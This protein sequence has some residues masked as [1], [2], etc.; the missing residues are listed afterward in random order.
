MR[1]EGRTLRS[2]R[3]ILSP[4]A[5]SEK[6]AFIQDAN[7]LYRLKE[8]DTLM[9]R[10]EAR[11]ATHPR[12]IPTHWFLGLAL[13][14]KGRYAEAL[15]AYQIIRKNLPKS[16]KGTFREPPTLLWRHIQAIQEKLNPTQ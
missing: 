7:I 13:E 12:D 1:L 11:A 9:K 3:I 16:E 10:A 15:E 14:K 4:P 6:T 8:Y 2:N 5:D